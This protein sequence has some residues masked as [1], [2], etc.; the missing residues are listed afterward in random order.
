MNPKKG[1]LSFNDALSRLTQGVQPNIKTES[2]ALADAA[3]RVLAE[4]VIANTQSPPYTNSAMDGYA[5]ALEQ[6]KLNT[7]YRVQALVSA[8]HALS[9]SLSASAASTQ[10]VQITTGALLPCGFD[11]VVIQEN[12]TRDG[13]YVVFNKL[14]PLGNNIRLAGED[15]QTGDCVLTKNTKLNAAHIGLLAS[16]GLANVSVYQRTRVGLIATGDELTSLGEPLRAGQLYNSNTPTIHA[17]LD[18]LNVQVTDYGVIADN[19]S[20]L[21]RAF[22]RA[23]SENDFVISTGGVSVGVADYT[24]TV[25]ERFGKLDFWKVA[26]KPGK[27]LVFGQ[28][29]NSYFTG[30]PGNPVSALVTFHLLGSQAIRVH[31]NTGAK[32]LIALTATLTHDLPKT[33]GRMDFQRGQFVT[34]QGEIKVSAT[35]K[36]QGS[37]LLSTLTHANCYL[38]LEQDRGPI[39]QGET[40]EIWLF[41]E[42][43]QS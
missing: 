8:G 31:Q 41:D 20:D 18:A 24:K 2:V 34:E 17:L 6:I 28:L 33:P 7:P 3:N 35:R 9:T 25:L 32:P 12:T 29:P 39:S 21:M 13:E 10:V 19:E 23:D 30:L 38:A 5:V 37:H 4:D 40:V 15:I 43:L 36:A 1:W 22:K 42:L 14:P 26:M 27:P 16:I 11:T